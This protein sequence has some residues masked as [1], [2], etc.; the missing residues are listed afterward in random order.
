MKIPLPLDFITVSGMKQVSN[1]LAA[2]NL[3]I[4]FFDNTR[5]YQRTHKIL[6]ATLDQRIIRELGML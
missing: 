3:F 1:R 2:N 5:H 6:T 4:L